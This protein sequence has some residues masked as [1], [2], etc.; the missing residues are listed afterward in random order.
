MDDLVRPP[1]RTGPQGV[2]G[3]RGSRAYLGENSSGA[4]PAFR[5]AIWLPSR[6]CTAGEAMPFQNNRMFS[7]PP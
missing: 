6:V 5:I 2:G 3:S 7:D 1:A 4:S